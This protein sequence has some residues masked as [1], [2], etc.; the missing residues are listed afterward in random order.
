MDWHKT[1]CIFNRI[2]IVRFASWRDMG[3]T[4]VDAG[5]TIAPSYKAKATARK[6]VTVECAVARVK[7]KT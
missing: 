7:A 6:D 2:F 1:L 3:V 5:L 4:H